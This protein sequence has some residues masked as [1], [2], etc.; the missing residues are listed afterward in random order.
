MKEQKSLES[1][2]YK[3]IDKMEAVFQHNCSD[4]S[5]W[6]NLEYDLNRTYAYD[7]VSFNDYLLEVREEIKK[8]TIEKIEKSQSNL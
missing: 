1:K 6:L 3:S 4:I 2:I 7:Q 5:T 8:D